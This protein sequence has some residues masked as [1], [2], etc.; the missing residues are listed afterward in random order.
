MLPN[1]SQLIDLLKND[2]KASRNIPNTWQAQF[3]WDE[4][5]DPLAWLA[6][7]PLYPKCF[8]QSRSGAK[9]V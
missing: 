8:W 9:M 7:Q 4:Q 1:F 3:C 6:G 2:L 5:I